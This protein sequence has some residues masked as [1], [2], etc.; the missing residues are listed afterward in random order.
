[1]VST[2]FEV[3]LLGTGAAFP[4]IELENTSLALRWEGGVWLI[5]CGGCPHRRLRLAGLDPRQLRGVLITHEHPDHLYG[6]P[7][8][9]HCLIPTPRTEPL[10]IL[11]PPAALRCANKVLEAF[12][13]LERPEVP[14]QLEEIPL[15]P[16][17]SVKHWLETDP[18]T[19]PKWE[20]FH[21]ADGLQLWAAP[22]NHTLETVGVRAQCG[23]RV[24]AYSSDTAPGD[25]VALLA[26]G[27]HLLVHE[28]TF[29]EADRDQMPAAHSTARDAGLA[30]SAAGV[31]TLVLVHFL[32][33]T[34]SQP[35]ALIM[36][37]AAVFAGRVEIGQELKRYD[38]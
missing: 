32:E 9:V 21:T 27:A 19:E 31:E 4:P 24:M 6:L 5:D 11:A 22:V 34:L 35:Q 33:P 16:R 2:P 17:S 8:L 13:M 7:S 14:L 29:R 28:A 25:G 26:R 37:A 12:A 36:E 10:V 18:S 15:I 1:M 30:A 38:V 3:I 20:P 23:G